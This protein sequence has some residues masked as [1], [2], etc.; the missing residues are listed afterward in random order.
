MKDEW[1]AAIK[2]GHSSLHIMDKFTLSMQIERYSTVTPTGA[3]LICLLNLCK[4]HSYLS[5]RECYILIS[6][7]YINYLATYIYNY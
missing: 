3:S 4:L 1:K 2:S 7:N 5:D 6:Y